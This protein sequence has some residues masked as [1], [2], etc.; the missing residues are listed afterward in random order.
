MQARPH[1]RK[2]HIYVLNPLFAGGYFL[3]SRSFQLSSSSIN[4]EVR[5]KYEGEQ[6]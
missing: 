1:R 5:I 6:E 4:E 3:N 2:D